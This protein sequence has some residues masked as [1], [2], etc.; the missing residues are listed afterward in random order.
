M[1]EFRAGQGRGSEGSSTLTAPCVL[2][3]DHQN[4]M[5]IVIP[6]ASVIILGTVVTAACIYN[7]QRKIQKYELQK[8]RKAQEE[9]A[10][11]LNTP[12]T[13]P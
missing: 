9:A 6:V 1:L 7:C 10:M 13:P 5:A 8:A 2:P 3:T 4:N 11:K 12:A